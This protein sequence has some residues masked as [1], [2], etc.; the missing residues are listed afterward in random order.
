[1]RDRALGPNKVLTSKK[2]VN[3]GHHRDVGDREGGDR[4]TAQ[5][6]GKSKGE[7]K[8]KP[9]APQ[10]EEGQSS[11]EIPGGD[12]KNVGQRTPKVWAGQRRH[13]M[14]GT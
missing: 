7:R 2:V 12:G 5:Q 8:R 11:G 13:K 1:M 4:K 6:E 14:G 3:S 10:G 9:A